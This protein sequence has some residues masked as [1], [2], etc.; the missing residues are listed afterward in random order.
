MNARQKAK[1]YKRELD[2]L[3]G[4]PLKPVYIH[5]DTMHAVKLRADQILPSYPEID[6]E[7][8]AMFRAKLV[9]ELAASEDFVKAV[10]FSTSV[11][12]FTGRIRLSAEVKVLR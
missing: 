6:D 12:E 5:E 2:I 10:R 9:R 7:T 3:K 11:D 1:K 4:I 8:N